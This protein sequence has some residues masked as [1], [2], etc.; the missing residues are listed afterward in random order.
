MAVTCILGRYFCQHLSLPYFHLINACDGDD[1]GDCEGDGCGH[2]VWDGDDDHEDDEDDD[3]EMKDFDED[4]ELIMP[5]KP[6]KKR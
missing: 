3:N 5:E 1:F 6:K 4:D 2:D